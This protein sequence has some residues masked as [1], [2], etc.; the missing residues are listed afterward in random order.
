MVADKPSQYKRIE[1]SD[2]G[3]FSGN[4]KK[5]RKFMDDLSQTIDTSM[6]GHL[7]DCL[8]ERGVFLP[9]GSQACVEITLDT[10][11]LLKQI[12][13]ELKG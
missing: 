8:L 13:G 2:W 9:E 5:Y 6:P 12:M 11:I 10:S 7:R 1:E 4:H 3:S